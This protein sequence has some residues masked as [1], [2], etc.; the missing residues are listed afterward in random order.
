MEASM[1]VNGSTFPYIST[2][3]NCVHG[4]TSTENSMVKTS[5]PCRT[6]VYDEY[7]R[8]KPIQD[9]GTDVVRKIRKGIRYFDA[10]QKSS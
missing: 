4:V 10:L 7:G 1:G 9:I 2:K 3:F 5:I 6:N 8:Y